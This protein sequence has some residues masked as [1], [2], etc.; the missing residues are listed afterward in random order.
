MSINKPKIAIVG[1]GP[2][3][4]TTSLFLSKHNIDHTLFEK[5]TF[6]RDKICGDGLTMEV[7][8]ALNE[9]DPDLAEEFTKLYFVKPSGGAFLGDVKGREIDFDYRT[10]NSVSPLFVAKRVLFD[11]WLFQKTK[12]SD[13]AT[14]KEGVGIDSIKRK[15]KGFILTTKDGEEFFDFLIGCDGERSVV[16]KYLTK[17]GI[18]KNRDHYAGAVRAY[19]KNVVPKRNY[20]PLEFY[21]LET[22]NGYFW[23]FHLE[24]NE[25]NVGLGGL[26]SEV[27]EKKINL[28]K[29]MENFIKD[30]PVISK[31]FEG[32]E[33]LEK[34]KGC[35]I[36]L[37]SN[38][39]DY[40]DDGFILIGD[41]ASMAEPLTGK[42]IGIGMMAG[43]LAIPTIRKAIELNDFSK[44]I[45]STYQ[46]A[47]MNKFEKE[48]DEL[49]K[50]VPL[51][52]KKSI[53]WSIFNLFKIPFFRNWHAKSTAKRTQKFM[54][55]KGY[56]QDYK[57]L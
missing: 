56:E 45:L 37:N 41:S 13:H 49:H 33:K 1:G 39:F 12:N 48:W 35:G 16:K 2:T 22:F 42:G 5:A 44:E 17:D 26:S 51:F 46:L 34:T 25:C 24:N 50:F 11:N 40:F 53:I 15:E 32:A 31:R 6:P 19:Y 47:I 8:R 21:P 57:N 55:S 38:R 9:I 23:I 3:G 29:E 28:I 30:N 43:Y 4:A 54:V 10:E 36:P 27:S 52:R 14:I 18:K 20:E 7:Y